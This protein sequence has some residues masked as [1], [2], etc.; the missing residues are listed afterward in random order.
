MLTLVDV[1]PAHVSPEE[2]K[3]I[4]GSTPASFTD[5]PPV[6]RWKEE[7]VGVALDPALDGW[8]EED[9]KEGTLFVLERCVLSLSIIVSSD[10][11]T[12]F[13]CSCQKLVEGFKFLIPPSLFMQFQEQSQVLVSTANLTRQVRLEEKEEKQMLMQR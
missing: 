2:H 5:I 12:V 3:N 1:V 7:G 10:K 9:G 13:W 4:V 6:L 11:T 8:S